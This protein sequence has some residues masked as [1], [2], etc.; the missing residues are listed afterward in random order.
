MH[1]DSSN[2]NEILADWGVDML[3]SG[4]A[5]AFFG[6][7]TWGT[8]DEQAVGESNLDVMRAELA[9]FDEWAGFWSIRQVKHG[10][11]LFV[12]SDAPDALI[13]L[14]RER[15][16]FVREDYPLLS[17][18]RHSLCLAELNLQSWENWGERHALSTVADPWLMEGDESDE[19][20]DWLSE[21]GDILAR[22]SGQFVADTDFQEFKVTT[23][24]IAR[25]AAEIA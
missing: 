7:H 9:E 16:V 24:E 3:Y 21:Q 12:S 18:E 6:Y 8:N 2:R 13:G 11:G 17:N 1:N 20:A 14:I 10:Q 4:H 25:F 5:W 15:E 22:W 23:D 19:W